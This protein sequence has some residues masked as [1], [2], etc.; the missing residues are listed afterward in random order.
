MTM[1]TKK[2]ATSSPDTGGEPR[3]DQSAD[4]EQLAC[5]VILDLEGMSCAACA[6]RIE[7]GLKKVPGV[8]DAVVNLATEQANITYDTRQ[9]DIEQMVKKVEMVGY[10]ATPAITQSLSSSSRGKDAETQPVQEQEEISRDGGA[11]GKQSAT[12]DEQGRR[13]QHEALRKRN[14]LL[15]GIALAIPVMILSMFFMNRFA[16]ENYLLLLLTTPIWSIVGWEFHRG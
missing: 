1:E 6:M 12:E 16:G 4:H 3:V 9:T 7:K 14:L 8:K 13:R 5:R 11:I 15:V 2:A 10:K